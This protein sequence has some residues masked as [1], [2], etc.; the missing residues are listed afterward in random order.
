MAFEFFTILWIMRVDWLGIDI[1]VL[2]QWDF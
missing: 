2:G 1:V